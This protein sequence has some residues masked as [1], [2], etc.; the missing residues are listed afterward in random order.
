MLIAGTAPTL[1]AQK[2]WVYVGTYTGGTSRGIYKVDLDAATLELGQPELVAEVRNP[3]FLA[4]H[5]TEPYL[6]AVGE[7]QEFEG[8]KVGAVSAFA[9]EP[10][11]GR[12]KLLNQ[13]P[14]GGAGPCHVTVD[15]SGRWVLVANYSGGTVS[16]LPVGDEGRLGPAACVV[17]HQ[18]QSVHPTRQTSPH[19]HQ[20]KVAPGTNLVLVPDLGTDQV[21]LYRLDRESGQLTANP[22]GSASLPPGSGP[23]HLAYTAGNEFLLVLN[24]L[25]SSVTLFRCENA[26]PVQRLTTISALPAD[27]RGENT[28]AEIVVHPSNKM[29]FTSNRGHDSIAIFRFDAAA[30][31]LELAGH[32]PSG[33]RTPRNFNLDPAGQ[34]LLSGNQNSDLIALYRVDLKQEKLV[35]TGKSLQVGSPVCIIFC[36]PR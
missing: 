26:V 24:E 1:W 21:M 19:P 15:A 3:S 31:R 11:T 28:G 12:L 22:P 6:Y 35:P 25:T 2:Y 9:I 4:L 13:Q 17:T 36:P 10:R 14:S 30:A 27:F 8:K 18:G 32:V 20:V 34:L 16:V 29:V 7:L 5:P 33:G 23:R